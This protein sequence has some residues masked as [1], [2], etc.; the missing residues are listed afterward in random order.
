[1]FFIISKTVFVEAINAIQKQEEEDAKAARALTSVFEGSFIC[2]ES[3]LLPAL[4]NVL[5]EACEDELGTIDWW[6][7][8]APEDF[9]KIYIS[10]LEVDLSTPEQMY[11]FLLSNSKEKGR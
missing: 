2:R 5:K 4:L 9:K 6:L 3:K 8:D 11:D 10:G 7:Y 1:M